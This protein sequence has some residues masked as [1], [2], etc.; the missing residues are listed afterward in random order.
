MSENNNNNNG[1]FERRR[2]S[3]LGR[4]SERTDGDLN[5]WKRRAPYTRQQVDGASKSLPPRHHP[6]GGV[7]SEETQSTLRQSSEPLRGDGTVEDTANILSQGKVL[8]SQRPSAYG[9]SGRVVTKRPADGRPSEPTRQASESGLDASNNSIS[10][11][12]LHRLLEQ[13]A[14]IGRKLLVGSHKGDISTL[15]FS[16]VASRLMCFAILITALYIPDIYVKLNQPPPWSYS[17]GRSLNGRDCIMS[18]YIEKF[19][20]NELN[21]DFVSPKLP[22][23]KKKKNS[24]FESYAKQP[25][26]E[27]VNGTYRTKGQVKVIKRFVEAVAS[28]YR[29]NYT[30]AQHLFFTNVRDS[31][32]LAQ[33]ALHHWPPRGTYRTQLHI[34]AADEDSDLNG[35]SLRGLEYGKLD[36]I[37]KRFQD[38]DKTRVHIYDRMGL[39]GMPDGDDDFAREDFLEKRNRRGK[40]NLTITTNEDELIDEDEGNSTISKWRRW[41]KGKKRRRKKT[42]PY[43][44]LVKFFPEDEDNSLVPYFQIDG[45]RYEDQLEILETARPLFANHLVG[46]VAVEHS[47]DLEVTDLIAWF[48]NVKYKTFFLGARQIHRLDHLCPEMLDDILSYPSVTKYPPL[49]GVERSFKYMLDFL[50]GEEESPVPKQ[51]YPSFFVALPKGRTSREEMTIQH[52]YDLFG[53]LDGGG[54]QIKTANDRKMPGK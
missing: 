36:A 31:G 15:P 29:S 40:S 10:K 39:A 50:L 47:Q 23:G 1:T 18:L 4:S 52:M 2:R 32:H 19:K 11:T 22:K 27:I 43:P 54:G 7:T 48:D 35:D 14:S 13:V 20:P 38:A 33:E 53:G 6:Q 8:N 42:H 21:Y 41:A 9:F 49:T 34:V 17:P 12:K 51:L 25:P 45:E 16:L 5:V 28:S 37:E 26:Y 46:A 3:T 30:I 44:D 24:S